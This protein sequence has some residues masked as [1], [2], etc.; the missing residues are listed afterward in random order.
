[1]ILGDVVVVLREGM[2]PLPFDRVA[3]STS[4]LARPISTS[5]LRISLSSVA[6]KMERRVKKLF[7]SAEAPALPP[8]GL[9]GMLVS[10]GRV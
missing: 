3:I 10:G 7:F 6:A 1:M 2:Q 5:G 9:L 8:N 4:S